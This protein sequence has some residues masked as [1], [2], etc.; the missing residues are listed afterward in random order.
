MQE[1][2]SVGGATV[3]ST[4][5]VDDKAGV[6]SSQR[7]LQYLMDNI[8]KLSKEYNERQKINIKKTNYTT[9]I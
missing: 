8:N 1:G 9:S 3:P 2:I 4:R 7:G 6:A 5:Y